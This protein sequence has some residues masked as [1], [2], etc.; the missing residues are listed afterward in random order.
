MP[1]E[2]SL[3]ITVELTDEEMHGLPMRALQELMHTRG[4]PRELPPDVQV[5][6]RSEYDPAR[7]VKTFHLVVYDATRQTE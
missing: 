4:W 1:T 2:P 3:H 5:T 7:C 6:T